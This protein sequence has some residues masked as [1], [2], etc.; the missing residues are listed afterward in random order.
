MTPP[1][2]VRAGRYMIVLYFSIQGG[3]FM[4]YTDVK[5]CDVFTFMYGKGRYYEA[6]ILMGSV[7]CSHC[8][9]LVDFCVT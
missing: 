5:Y 7:I 8:S 1:Q 3:D 6:Y 4:E 9:Q 2:E